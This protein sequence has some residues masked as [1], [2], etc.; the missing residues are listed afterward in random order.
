MSLNL[1]Q[2]P[3]SHYCEK[4]RWALDYKGLDHRLHNHLP[5]F[6]VKRIRRMAPRTSVPVLAHDGKVVQGSS[7]I[8]THLDEA[9]PARPLTPSDQAQRNQVL[10]W[11]RYCDSEIG[12]HVRRL[13][14]D[15]LLRHPR[16][17]IPLLAHDGPFWGRPVLRL[18]F[19]RLRRTMR[20]FMA[21]REPEVTRSR[22]AL[23]LALDELNSSLEGRDYLVGGH[24]TRA[25]LAAAS[26]LA[27]LFMP[28][29]YGLDWPQ[30]VPSPLRGWVD[31]HQQ[32][33]VWAR[34]MYE[35]HRL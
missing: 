35:H 29:G 33:L 26:L 13:C 30:S 23:E 4:V 15:T 6:H 3:I 7:D 31:N 18:V 28:A 9:F 27:P 1:H 11:E 19:P 12:P 22:E 20:R 21:I 5:G 14:Y 16:Q 8:I 10:E 25:D 34:Q 32:Q 2:F 24:F 17:V